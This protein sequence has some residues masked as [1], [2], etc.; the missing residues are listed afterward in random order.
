MARHDDRPGVL[1][2]RLADR[3]RQRAVAELYRDVAVGQRRTRWDGAG[4]L[5]DLPVERRQIAHIERNLTK[6]M[7]F[8]ADQRDNDGGGTGDLARGLML[9]ELGVAACVPGA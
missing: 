6:V 7:A 5:I 8:A 3:L 4:G 2:E 1:S 9:A